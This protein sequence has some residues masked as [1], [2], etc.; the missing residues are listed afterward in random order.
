MRRF[1]I[2]LLSLLAV[3]G[4][5][6]WVAYAQ[7]AHFISNRSVA[8]CSGDNLRVCFKE[9]GLGDAATNYSL[10]ATRTATYMCVNGGGK[11]PSDPKKTTVSEIGGVTGTFSP[12]NGT[13]ST[14]LD[15]SPPPPPAS[16]SCPSGQRVSGPVDVA[17]DGITLT[18]TSNN[19]AAELPVSSQ[20][21]P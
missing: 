21:C 1:G 11:V 3:A 13:V 9:A 2:A 10:T 12:K 4:A 14:C 6:L 17:Y 15:L 20:S 19:V 8:T 16:F 7:N 5:S 18:D